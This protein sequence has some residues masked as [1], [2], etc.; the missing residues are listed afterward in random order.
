MTDYG[1]NI[2]TIF[3]DFSFLRLRP[4][5]HILWYKE[6]QMNKD[7]LFGYFISWKSKKKWTII[8]NKPKSILRPCKER[9]Q[10]ED[11]TYFLWD[12]FFNKLE[13]SRPIFLSHYDSQ[14]SSVPSSSP[15]HCPLCFATHTPKHL[16]HQKQP[17]F[18]GMVGLYQN[19]QR[20]NSV[21]L[22]SKFQNWPMRLKTSVIVMSTKGF[23]F[24]SWVF[25]FQ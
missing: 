19:A 10:G 2:L 9:Q 8:I 12:F 20:E 13:S 14:G 6:S 5:W 23:Y 7:K 24:K 21:T 16:L 1:V 15:L 11:A 25:W 22:K 4:T 18:P 3:P 17:L